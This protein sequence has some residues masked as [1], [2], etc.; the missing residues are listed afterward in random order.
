MSLLIKLGQQVIKIQDG[1][2]GSIAET[3]GL[4]YANKQ[5]SEE[6]AHYLIMYLVENVSLEEALTSDSEAVQALAKK[7]STN[8]P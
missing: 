7:W 5:A 1:F 4:E 8:E 6:L 3:D 2:D